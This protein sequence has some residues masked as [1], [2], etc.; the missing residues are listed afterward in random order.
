VSP[1]P[2][3]SSVKLRAVSDA[4][5][6][7]IGTYQHYLPAAFLGRFSTD[8]KKRAR[9]RTLWVQSLAAPRSYV[10]SASKVGGEIGL[11]DVDDDSLRPERTL[12]S[13]W[14]Y[15]SFVPKALDALDGGI[16]R[17][18]AVSGS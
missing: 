14:G 15:E 13:A 1:G 17:R 8:A 6:S 12:D 7:T 5:R 18:T 16:S 11:Y 10:S 2:A 3:A 4:K 9:S